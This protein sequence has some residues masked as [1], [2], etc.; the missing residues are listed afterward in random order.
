MN[1]QELVSVIGLT[2]TQLQ[3]GAVKAVNQAQTIR[4]WLIGFYIVEFEQN[5]EDHAQYGRQLL[6]KL[7]QRLDQ[8]GLNVTLFQ[9]A[10]TFY[11][12]YPQFQK[13]A[14]QFCPLKWATLLPK[15]ENNTGEMIYATPLPK[16]VEK[17]DK[18]NQEGIP[19]EKL[20][21]SVSFAHFTELIKI[22][23]P[24][25]R[26]YYEILTI[27]TGLSVRELK[28]QINTLSYERVGLSGDMQNSLE[29]I[30]KK[31]HPQS[32][33]DAIKDDYFFEFLDIPQE[34]R[35]YVK[36]KDLETLLLDNLR[37]FILELGNGFCLEAR[38]KRILIGDEFYFIDLVFYHRILKAHILIELKVDKFDH[39][40]A[41]QLNTYLNYYRN[42]M[43][44]SGDNPP[45]GILLVTDKNETLVQYATTGL[46]EK[47]FV[48]KYRLQLPSEQQLHDLIMKNLRTA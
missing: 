32:V 45:I 20:L 5:G 15:L 26:T 17:V 18:E 7:E 34:N 11:F 44:E 9:R 4:N 40:H 39:S 1:F 30:K 36:E 31:I 6:I 22:S 13:L 47:I 25:K 38:Q 8:K 19:V 43:M 33:A 35:K 37:D 2:H 10:R 46:D 29:V 12:V 14:A 27:Q 28:R 24:V 23:D 3:Q 48:S 42:E 16:F 21:S 41:S